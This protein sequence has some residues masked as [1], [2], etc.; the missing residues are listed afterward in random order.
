MRRW[1]STFPFIGVVV[2]LTA[3]VN[4]AATS[5]TTVINFESLSDLSVV[6]NQFLA[7]GIDFNGTANILSQGGILS[8]SFPPHSGTNLIGQSAL[9]LPAAAV[10]G[11]IRIDA[12]GS[13][14][15]FVGGFVTDGSN[16]LTL[17]AFD[18]VGNILGT[19]TLH[20]TN[21]LGSPGLSPNVFLSVSHPGIAFAT[22]VGA[23][24][25]FTVDD[26]TFAPVAPAVA[27]PHTLV[28]MATGSAMLAAMARIRLRVKSRLTRT[29]SPGH[30]CR[31]SR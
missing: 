4:V 13:L 20:G 1:L 30:G 29:G 21:T 5:A 6:D 12:V 3:I 28:V 2:C 23:P 31:R 26:V 8:P 9:A 18:Q 25:F 27:E 24:N 7:L 19:D 11:T 17:T 15:S 10:D 16:V 22:F 14:W